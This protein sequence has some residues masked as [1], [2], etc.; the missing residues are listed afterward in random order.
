MN[1]ETVLY[2]LEYSPY[3]KKISCI[4]REMKCKNLGY[5]E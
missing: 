4:D 5:T 3:T 2:T 1:G